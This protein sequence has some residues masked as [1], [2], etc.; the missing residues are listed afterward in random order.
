MRNRSKPVLTPALLLED[1]ECTLR[2]GKICPIHFRSGEE[3]RRRSE[4]PWEVTEPPRANQTS[5]ARGRL[6]CQA[7]DSELSM[8]S[9]GDD[10]H[11]S[12]IAVV[13]RIDDE[14]VVEGHAAERDWKSVIGLEDLFRTWMRE[15]S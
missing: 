15:L 14:L 1:P 9:G 6:S 11:W 10:G 7:I 12:A 2:T 8:Q 5:C 13:G 3:R 4:L